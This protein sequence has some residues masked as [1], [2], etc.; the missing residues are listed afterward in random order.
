[1]MYLGGID[2]ATFSAGAVNDGGVT[3]RRRRRRR[4]AIRSS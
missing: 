3:R 2:V 4:S 1:M